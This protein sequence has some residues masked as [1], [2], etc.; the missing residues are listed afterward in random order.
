MPN[1][2]LHTGIGLCT[3]ACPRAQVL[4]LYLYFTSEG[5]GP[6]RRLCLQNRA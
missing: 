6:G 2:N 3:R 1:R 5:T 4:D